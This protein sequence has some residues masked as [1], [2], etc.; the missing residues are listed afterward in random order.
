MAQSGPVFTSLELDALCDYVQF[1]LHVAQ[2]SRV[3][4]F[5][6]V[7]PHERWKKYPAVQAAEHLPPRVRSMLER[8]AWH[9][10]G[11]PAPADAIAAGAVENLGER[12]IVISRAH[13]HAVLLAGAYFLETPKYQIL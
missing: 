11:A 8:Y 6:G 13:A 12:G 7:A 5:E 4:T 2:D 1:F 9:R 3:T 10:T